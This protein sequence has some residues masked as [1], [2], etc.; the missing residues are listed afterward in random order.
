M[1]VYLEVIGILRLHPKTMELIALKLMD[2]YNQEKFKK[3]KFCYKRVG[4]N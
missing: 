2:L 4:V 3:S 1:M